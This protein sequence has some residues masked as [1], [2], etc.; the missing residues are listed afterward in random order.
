MTSYSKQISELTDILLNSTIF[1]MAT[2]AGISNLSDHDQDLYYSQRQ[3][4]LKMLYSQNHDTDV[5][6]DI[7]AIAENL[8]KA[9]M[10]TCDDM[11]RESKK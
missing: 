11:L 9:E 1:Q 2:V 7:L 6:G 4:L 10:R 5:S 8:A 3:F